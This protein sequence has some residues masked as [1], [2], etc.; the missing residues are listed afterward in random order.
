[1]KPARKTGLGR[2]LSALL[3]DVESEQ[4]QTA[5]KQSSMFVP[6]EL[7]KVNPDQPRRTFIEAD[8]ADLTASIAE[9]G[10]IQPLILRP[11][12][13]NADSYQIVAGER[14]WRAAQRAKLHEVP[15]VVMDLNDQEVLE[16]AIIENIQRSD[17]NPIEEALGFRQLMTKFGHTQEELSKVL[18]KSRSYIAN[19][20]RLL[21][22]PDTV[23][24]MVRNGKLT[25]GHARAL[26][27][28]ENPEKAARKIVDEGLS[29]REAEQLARSETSKASPRR[30]SQ[31]KDA[32]TRS[33]EADLS[34]SLG[35]SV[36]IDQKPGKESGTVSISFKN[37]EELDGI[38][39]LLTK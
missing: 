10:V 37:L 20:L 3:A 1:M 39:R 21:N 38:C 14:R 6:I 18:G 29:V 4:E 33:L 7:I 16:L 2:G 25:A 8:L 13:S 32:D 28:M 11:D 31:V 17:L 34:A 35:T 9:K 19:L 22:L 12:P 5:A 23:V 30:Q 24:N 27:P 36:S 15:V 26:I